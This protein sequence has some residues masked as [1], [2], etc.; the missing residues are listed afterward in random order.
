MSPDLVFVEFGIAADNDQVTDLHQP[1]CGTVQTDDSGTWLSGDGVS[2]QSAAVV[3]VVD[4]DLFPLHDI[5]GF[6]QQRIDGD[7]A[8]VM[9]AGVSHGSAVDFGFQQDS[10]HVSTVELVRERDQARSVAESCV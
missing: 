4:I 9:Q 8:F 7:T 3:D 5:D 6:H 1:G 2:G 10:F